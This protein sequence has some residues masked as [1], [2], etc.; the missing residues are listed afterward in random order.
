MDMDIL[1]F[2]GGNIVALIGFIVWLVRLESKTIN[3]MREFEKCQISCS[4]DIMEIRDQNRVSI[5]KL[6]RTIEK[7]SVTMNS[8]NLSFTENLA[9]LSAIVENLQASMR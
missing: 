3:M 1:K 9:K 6:E 4:A 2:I 8:F 5:D 7:L